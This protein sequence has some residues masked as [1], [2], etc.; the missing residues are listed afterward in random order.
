MFIFLIVFMGLILGT[1]TKRREFFY[2]IVYIIRGRSAELLK[3]FFSK[4]M[5]F[6]INVNYCRRPRE[7]NL[8]A[9]YELVKPTLSDS[10]PMDSYNYNKFLLRYESKHE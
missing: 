4:W 5:I 6:S 9:N 10:M 1:L 8:I 2:T 7:R 3:R